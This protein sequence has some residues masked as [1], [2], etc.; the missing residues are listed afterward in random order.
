MDLKGGLFIGQGIG[1]QVAARTFCSIA[2]M[3]C[4]SQKLQHKIFKYSD[5]LRG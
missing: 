1:W 5:R 4:K 3:A 2:F